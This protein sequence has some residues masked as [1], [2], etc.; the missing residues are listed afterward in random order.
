MTFGSLFAGIG[1]F[2]LGLERAGLDCQWQVEIDDYATQVLEKHW[3]LV[4]RWRDVRYFPP[5]PI[6]DWRVD[7]IC[8]GFP[9][10][11]ISNAGRRRGIHGERSKLFFEAVRVV[12]LLRPRWVLLENVAAILSNG[13]GVVGAEFSEIGYRL[14]WDCIPASAVGANHQRDRIFL[15]AYPNGDECDGARSEPAHEACDRGDDAEHPQRRGAMQPERAGGTR[16]SRSAANAHGER[17][18]E[19]QVLSRGLREELSA[20]E[21]DNV[22]VGGQWGT[23]PD[24]LRMAHGI[25]NRVDRIR[26]LGNAVV[27]QVAEWM[28]RVI[29]RKVMTNGRQDGIG[30]LQCG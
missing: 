3:P 4:R 11:D 17:L 26:C 2:D 15:L 19:R 22:A 5:E 28:G 25:P 12:G 13:M 8:G 9:C 23:E 20:F 10:Q 30:H 21:R 16:V 27:P 18:A 29:L 24:I 7:L 14:E 6:G 1:G